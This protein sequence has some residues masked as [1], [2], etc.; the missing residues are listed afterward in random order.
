MTPDRSLRA[1]LIEDAPDDTELRFRGVVES[2]AEGL[3]ITDLDDRIVYA[4]PRM[5]E[6]VGRQVDAV[7]GQPAYRVLLPEERWEEQKR[8]NG[9]RARGEA[10]EYDTEI[11]RLDGERGSCT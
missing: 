10:E 4:N 2:L 1:Q 7:V 8:R 9:D 11:V 6:M 3:V 5:A